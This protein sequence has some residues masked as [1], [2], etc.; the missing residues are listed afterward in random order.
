MSTNNSREILACK[1]QIL[2][3]EQREGERQRAIVDTRRAS[4]DIAKESALEVEEE[5]KIQDQG[6]QKLFTFLTIVTR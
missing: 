6:R 4:E 1:R 3:R 5:D 2:S